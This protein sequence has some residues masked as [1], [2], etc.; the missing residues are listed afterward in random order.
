MIN[1]TTAGLPLGRPGSMFS[2]RGTPAKNP[3]QTAYWLRR[4][5]AC[6]Q[7][8]AL[9]PCARILKMIVQTA[10]MAMGPLWGS[11]ALTTITAN[12]MLANPRGPNQPTN[13][14]PSSLRRHC[15]AV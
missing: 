15:K 1:I 13:S 5:K 9:I 10:V 14:L 12:T 7:G 3:V 2:I 8:L 11:L 6:A 4:P